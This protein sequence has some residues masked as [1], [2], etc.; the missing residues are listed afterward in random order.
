L[1]FFQTDIS[2]ETETL[3]PDFERRVH[4][5]IVNEVT[6]KIEPYVP[7]YKRILYYT[8]SFSIVLLMVLLVLAVVAGIVVYRLSVS[9]AFNSIDREMWVYRWKPIIVP[10]TG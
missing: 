4:K 8:S 10:I 5:T 1:S 7:A 9:A 2:E 6:D 3:R